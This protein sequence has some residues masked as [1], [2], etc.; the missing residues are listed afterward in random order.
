MAASEE[1][2][3][4]YLALLVLAGCGDGTKSDSGLGNGSDTGSAGSNDGTGPALAAVGE[5]SNGECPDM[6]ETATSVFTS[7]NEDRVVTM[8]IP[9]DPPDDMPLVF[10]FHG[11]M[12]PGSTPTPTEYMASVLGL[13]AFA[14][15]T[16]TAFAVPQSDVISRAGFT[17]FMWDVTASESGDMTLFDDIRACASRN[18]SVDLKRVHAV[19]MSGGALFTTTVA[20]ARGD[21]LASIVEMSGGSDIDMLTFD[22][23]LSS[24]YTPA[25]PMPALLIAGGSTDTWPGGGLTLLDFS[26][27]TDT[28]EGQLVAD[29]HFVV[30]CEH[31]QG[32]AIPL[33]AIEATEIWV[34]AH[35]FGEPSSIEASGIGDIGEFNGWCDIAN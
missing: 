15:R 6:S 17:F 28:L 34:D 30:R 22:T 11:L 29:D 33:A 26:A 19:G 8:V 21:S 24:S 32:H 13:Q 1:A 2:M 18:L 20:G 14:N 31:T 5:P 7:S 12:D 35:R 9:E 27:A 10:F 25:Y 23:P 3:L 16:G 4:K